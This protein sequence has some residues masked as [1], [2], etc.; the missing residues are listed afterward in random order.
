MTIDNKVLHIAAVTFIWLVL[1]ML[2]TMR[3]HAE[4]KTIMDGEYIIAEIHTQDDAVEIQEGPPP[5]SS[6][7]ADR[8]STQEQ[9]EEPQGDPT[10]EKP[11]RKRT[12]R[13]KKEESE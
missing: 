2:M 3:S 12:T 4:T 5:D 11:K 9:P 10:A 1:I 6:S 8:E 13:R 7:D